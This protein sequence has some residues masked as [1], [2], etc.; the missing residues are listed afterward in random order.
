M[1]DAR[2]VVDG[3]RQAFHDIRLPAPRLD[4]SGG[5]YSRSDA[6]MPRVAKRRN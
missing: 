5:Q 6:V 3:S 2:R 1:N 4:A